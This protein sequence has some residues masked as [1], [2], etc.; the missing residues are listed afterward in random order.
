MDASVAA[1]TR[2]K[3]DLGSRGALDGAVPACEGEWLGA[4]KGALEEGQM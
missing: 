3:W 1:S 4:N 2:N